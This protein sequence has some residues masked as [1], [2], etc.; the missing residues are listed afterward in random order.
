[1]TKEPCFACDCP[2]NSKYL[3]RCIDEQ[4][5]FIGSECFKR[6]RTAGADGWQPSKGG[7][8]LFTIQDAPALSSQDRGTDA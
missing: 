6:V 7:P 3:V 1:V 8:R 2:M 5:V 4:T